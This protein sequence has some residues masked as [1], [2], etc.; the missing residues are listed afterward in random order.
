MTD[1]WSTTLDDLQRTAGGN[2]DFLGERLRGPAQPL[3]EAEVGRFRPRRGEKGIR[4]V[5][6]AM[7]NDANEELLV[8]HV[9]ILAACQITK[10]RLAQFTANASRALATPPRTN[11][12]CF[13]S[14]LPL[15][16]ENLVLDPSDAD[17]GDQ[18]HIRFAIVLD[19]ALCMKLPEHVATEVGEVGVLGPC[20]EI[21]CRHS[22]LYVRVQQ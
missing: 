21:L 22:C 16:L 11:P 2:A 15:I 18:R 10:R 8:H 7:A 4:R 9:V 20:E 19:Q 14:R 13:S 1:E 17:R 12:S 5:W 6:T 3:M